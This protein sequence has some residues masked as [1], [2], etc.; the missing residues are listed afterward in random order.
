MQSWLSVD[1]QDITS[2]QVSVD[3]LATNLQLVCDSFSL[4]KRHVLQEELIAGFFIFHDVG[5]WML[6]RSVDNVLTQATIT[7]SCNTFWEGQLSRHEDWHTDLVSRDVR[8][9]RNDTPSTEVDTLAHHFHSEHAFLAL[10]E[11]SNTWL[12]FIDRL[13]CHR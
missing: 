10:E 8:V 1:E 7:D 2:H 9:G 6:R 3:D 4:L 5:S 13:G 11:L 12:C